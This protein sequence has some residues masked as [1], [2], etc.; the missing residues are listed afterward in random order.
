MIRPLTKEELEKI[1]KIDLYGLIEPLLYQ[2]A[3]YGDVRID[4]F[5]DMLLNN[6]IEF[7]KLVVDDED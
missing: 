2:G 1:D 3:E 7:L 4:I 5:I 6:E